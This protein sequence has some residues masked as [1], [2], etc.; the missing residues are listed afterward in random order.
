[1]PVIHTP[2]SRASALVAVG[3]TG[4]LAALVR[5]PLMGLPLD[6]DEGGYLLVARRWA[7][8][9]RLYTPGA[10]VDRPPGLLLAF[11]WVG[12]V[13]YSATG[14][15]VAALVPAVLVTLAAASVAWALASRTAAVVAGLLTAVALAGP[16][17]QGYQL[18]G[19]LLAGSLA[20][21]GVAGAVWW[22]SAA[23]STWTLAAA[24]LVAALAPLVKQSALDGV[25]VVLAVAAASRRWRAVG[26]ALLGVAV[27]VVAVV[28]AAARGGWDRWWYALVH[29]QSEL[30]GAQPTG[31]RFSSLYH[32]LVHVAPDLLALA[33]AAG[34]GCALAWRARRTTWP[35]MV[36]AAV[37]VLAALVGPFGHPHY[38][39]QAVAPLAV[40]AALAMPRL[41]E[42]GTGARRAA[43]VVLV[44]ALLAPLASQAYVLARTGRDRAWAI[45]SDGRLAANGDV[46]DWLR[47]HAEPGDQVFALAASADLYLLSGHGTSF[48]Y[49]WYESVQRVP[50]AK[51]L[52]VSWLGSPDAPRYVVV[53]HQP[54]SVDPSGRLKQVLAERYEKVATVDGYDILERRA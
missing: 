3:L 46:A 27:P 45:S 34:V 12:D 13:A 25:V 54:N 51:D 26:A 7:E 50:G 18:N 15:R 1:V 21:A 42:L 37:A 16:Y 6:P 22:R 38:W 41:S 24:G 53:Y 4:L 36:W 14:V 10:W 8:G 9:A 32:G 23:L 35:A 39:V 29:F 33:V 47:T 20:A 17:V 48:P 30:S 43:V 28:V 49:L 44:A 2:R 19:E 31:R 11:R 40:L 5:L 52:L